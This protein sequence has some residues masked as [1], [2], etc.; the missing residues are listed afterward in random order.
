MDDLTGTTPPRKRPLANITP[1]PSRQIGTGLAN[2]IP[3]FR[4]DAVCVP[5]RL[6]WSLSLRLVRR[7]PWPWPWIYTLSPSKLSSG[8][9]VVG[10][11]GSSALWNGGP[12]DRRE[13]ADISFLPTIPL[14]TITC[15]PRPPGGGGV[16][17]LTTMNRERRPGNPWNLEVRRRQPVDQLEHDRRSPLSPLQVPPRNLPLSSHFSLDHSHSHREMCRERCGCHSFRWGPGHAMPCTYLL[18]QVIGRGAG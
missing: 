2:T 6:V 4:R 1:R 7:L 3:R 16:E 11:G 5:S 13:G 17:R 15:W 10:R 12:P 8:R 18:L 14:Y 9:W